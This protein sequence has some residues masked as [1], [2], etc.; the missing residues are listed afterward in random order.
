VLRD[1]RGL[2]AD[3]E[4]RVLSWAARTLVDGM[5]AEAERG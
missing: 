2:D 1:V 3:Q 5:P 4:E